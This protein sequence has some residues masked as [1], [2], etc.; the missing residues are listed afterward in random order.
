M[1]KIIICFLIPFCF[2]LAYL[3]AYRL[4]AIT[5]LQR[6][7]HKTILY[8]K[9]NTVLSFLMNAADL[10]FL[11]IMFG[12]SE[13]MVAKIK[14]DFLK[15]LSLMNSFSIEEIMGFFIGFL[16]FSFTTFLIS[17]LLLRRCINGDNHK[18]FRILFDNYRICLTLSVICVVYLILAILIFAA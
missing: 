6:D 7:P 8:S 15:Y 10:F 18:Y 2:A 1:E 9:I 3:L 14:P 16:L 13:S 5:A 17:L 11:F 4:V 12:K